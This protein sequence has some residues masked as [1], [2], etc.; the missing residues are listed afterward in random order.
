MAVPALMQLRKRKTTRAA[1]TTR[2]MA[3]LIHFFFFRGMGTLTAF[4]PFCFSGAAGWTAASCL[5]WDVSIRLTP[6]PL[7]DCEWDCR[8][9]K[10]P[11]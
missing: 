11:A 10:R 2:M 4:S 1:S 7:T 3:R 5:T 8:P 9:E 6:F